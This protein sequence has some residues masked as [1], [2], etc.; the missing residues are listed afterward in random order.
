M[1]ISLGANRILTAGILIA[2]SFLIHLWLFL[3]DKIFSDAV[4]FGDLSLYNFWAY[5]VQNGSPIYGIGQD[6]VYPALAFL[7]I[8]LAGIPSAF[9]YEL[10]WLAMVFLLNTSASLLLARPGKKFLSGSA[11][12]FVFLAGFLFLGPVAISRIDAVSVSIAVAAI[13]AVNRQ[14]F[15]YAVGLLTIAGWIK[16]WPVAV[17]LALVASFKDK[18]KAFLVAGVISLAI[19]IFGLALGGSSVFSFISQQQVRGIQIESVLATPWMW[20]AKFDLSKIYFDSEVLTNQVTGPFVAEVASV[21][22]LVLFVALAITFLL[23]RVAIKAGRDPKEVFVI[24]SL[25]G[26]LDLIVFNKVGSPQFMLWL[27]V[28]LVAGVYFG[29]KKIDFASWSVFLILLLTQLVYPVFYIQL[30]ALEDLP[31][32]ALTLRN[33]LLVAVLVWANLRLTSKKSL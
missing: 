30:L 19:I 2:T 3:A 18:A 23:A 27:L 22:N 29:I 33:V 20:L 4:S 11:A 26:V 10:S 12:S 21:T 5:E 31:L 1:K 17:F 28:P 6:W 16:I 15:G 13:Y 24:A 9:S 7:P 25:I 32:W 14:F 8:W